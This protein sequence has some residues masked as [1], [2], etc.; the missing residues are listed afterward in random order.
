M[1]DIEILLREISDGIKEMKN[2]VDDVEKEIADLERKLC[3]GWKNE[4]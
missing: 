3:G 4:V 2:K 1:S